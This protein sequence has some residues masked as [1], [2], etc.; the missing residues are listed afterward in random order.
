MK[1]LVADP[2]DFGA[3]LEESQKAFVT[4]GLQPQELWVARAFALVAVAGEL[5]TEYGITGWPEGRHRR[6]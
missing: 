5:A 2:Q 1:R 6:L 3:L 4:D